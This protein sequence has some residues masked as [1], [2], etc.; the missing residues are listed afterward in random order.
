MT[1]FAPASTYVPIDIDASSWDHLQP[2]YA[3]LI[4][5]KLMCEGCLEQLLL[6]RSELDAAAAEAGIVAYINNSRQTDDEDAKAKFLDWVEHVQPHLQQ[7][8]FELNRKIVESPHVDAL[9]QERYGVMLRELK[10]DVDLFREENIPLQ[11][12]EIKL[13]QQYDEII[14]AMMIEEGGEEYTLPQAAK[15]LQETDRALRERVYRSIWDRRAQDR[16]ALDT[17]FEELLSIRCQIATNAGCTDYRQYMFRAKYRFDYTPED[18]EAFH[19]G[20]EEVCVPVA[21]MLDSQRRASLELEGLR[22]WDMDVDAQGR[23][24]LRPFPDVETLITKTSGLFHRMDDGL[25]DLFDR[26]R[27]GDCL[28]LDS[29]K[30]KAPGGYQAVRERQRIPF[31]FMNAAGMQRDLE[32][33]VHEA[34][35]AF[36]SMLCE[37]EPLLHYRNAPIEFAEVA[38]MSMELLSFP[39]LDEF[40][41]SADTDRSRRGQLEALSRMLPWIARVDAFQHWIY[42][43]PDHTRQERTQ[44]WLDLD[45]RFGADVLW[46]GIEAHRECSW[47]RQLHI[48]CVPFYYI[49]YGIAQLGALQLWLQSRRD[50]EG[51]IANYRKAM[52]LGGSR[53]LPELFATAGL[54]FSFGPEAMGALLDEVRSVLEELPA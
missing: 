2:L 4:D 39:Y 1:T 41:D 44:A 51:A 24:P 37:Q 38:S 5:R 16:D 28:D 17:I 15:F 36:H 49:E 23:D 25:G 10:T 19:K 11:T 35:H 26:L 53:P 48:F 40:Y 34:G 32:T 18:C 21:S 30:G 47:Q 52:S 9:D 46:D 31:I 22:P 43:H 33:M 20:A 54:D 42:T 14:G 12:E 8:S 6:D 13:G 29:R 50:E 45:E 3:G 7:A 27:S